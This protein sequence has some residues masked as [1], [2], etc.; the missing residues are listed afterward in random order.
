MLLFGCGKAVDHDQAAAPDSARTSAA[1]R[2]PE[3]DLISCDGIGEIML[4]DDLGSLVKKAGKDKITHDSLFLEGNF[5]RM[6]TRVGKGTSREIVVYWKEKE[7]PFR[8]IQML[9]ISSRT[10]PYHFASG[11]NIG[12]SLKKLVELNG[13]VPVS[14]YGFGWDYGGTF[15]SFGNGKLAGP[16]ACFGGVFQLSSTDIVTSELKQ[17]MGDRKIRSDAE[18]LKQY[19]ATLVKIRV[20]RPAADSGAGAERPGI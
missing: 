8:T 13:G 16:L 10:S 9:E 5:E 20:S 17:V 6:I 4:N 11:I 18:A 1:V 15:I 14:L 7:Q 3:N 12:T 2:P 19:Q